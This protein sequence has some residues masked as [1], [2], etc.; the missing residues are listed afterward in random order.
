MKRVLILA[1]DFPP[2]NTVGAQRPYSWFLYF[3][4][5]GVMPVVI[6]R[7]WAENISESEDLY[8]SSLKKDVVLTIED[9]GEIIKTPYKS[10]LKDRLILSKKKSSVFKFLRKIV[11]FY[12]S[13]LQFLFFTFD[14]KKQIYLEA[15]K[16]LK[17]NKC[18]I[19]ITS[20]EPFV[21][22]RYAN[23]LS[24][25]FGI[26]WIAD[27]RDGWSTNSHPNTTDS[28]FKKVQN[29]LI[30]KI[31]KAIVKTATII[32]VAAEE[33]ASELRKLFPT[34]DVHVIFNGYISEDF[35][36]L[37]EDQTKDVFTIAYLGTIYPFQRIEMFFNA[38][39]RFIKEK[40]IKIRAEFYGSKFYDIEKNLNP[41]GILKDFVVFYPRNSMDK[42]IPEI[43]KANL[44]LVLGMKK[45]TALAAKIFDYLRMNRKIMLV[46]NDFGPLE[47]IIKETDSGIVCDNENEIV[48][49]LTKLYEEWS[50]TGEVKST[51]K[52]I[53]KYS[54]EYQAKKLVELINSIT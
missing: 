4:K 21:L 51:T 49:A 26:P 28:F 48:A 7:H 16:Y 9:L 44:L 18:S 39:S 54:R 30:R 32:T 43:S 17:V 22:F 23:I 41:E 19:I 15:K 53:D 36:S 29:N 5:Y 3:K 35:Q 12:Y 37:I 47:K 31:E 25:E 13:I 20:G 27:Y 1:Y 6:T 11:T 40:D 42:I 46:N 24:K 2:L 8:K 14:N 50:M 10:D 34:K 38:L 33:Y 45:R 52:N